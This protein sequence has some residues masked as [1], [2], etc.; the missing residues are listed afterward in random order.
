VEGR[1][2]ITIQQCKR[3]SLVGTIKPQQIYTWRKKFAPERAEPVVFLLALISPEA[4][5]ES[6]RPG[7][8]DR[9][10]A[11]KRLTRPIRIEIGWKGARGTVSRYSRSAVA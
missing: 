11:A 10:A 6:D 3:Q 4:S 9:Y 2:R 7:V 1:R 5:S 8:A